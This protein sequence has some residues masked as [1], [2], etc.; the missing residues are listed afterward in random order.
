MTADIHA[1]LRARYIAFRAG[2][3][4][5][6]STARATLARAI[7]DAKRVHAQKI[8]GHFTDSGD[9]WQL[10]QGTQAITNYRTMTPACDSDASLPDA[11]LL[12][13]FYARFEAENDVVAKKNTPL[14]GEQVL[15]L[16]KAEVRKTLQRVNLHKVA[17]PDNVPGSVLKGCADQLADVL[18]DIFNISLSSATIPSCFKATTIIPVP[19]K[20]LVSCL[21][22]HCPIT[23]T[24]TI[25]KYFERLI[26]RHIKNLLPPTL[27]PLQFVYQT[28]CS[29]DD[30]ITTRV[31]S[32]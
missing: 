19:K 6:L 9:T 10:W 5:A 7:R 1:V 32:L 3:K 11:S 8:H 25:M 20:S 28:I 22:D 26:L 2:D 30:A 12:N 17:G 18:T 13:V 4:E 23:F 21:N 15:C 16:T 24:P 27:D 29:T 14:P 31:I